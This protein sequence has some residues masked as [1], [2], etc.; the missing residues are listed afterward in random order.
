MT[1]RSITLLSLCLA[2][3]NAPT[4]RQDS[5]CD[6]P[7]GFVGWSG[8]NVRWRGLIVDASPHGLGFVSEDCHRRGAAIKDISSGAEADYRAFQRSRKTSWVRVELSAKLT[9]NGLIITKF[10]RLEA[11]SDEAALR[12]T[13]ALGF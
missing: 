3:C 5:L 4:P 6:L 13:R 11:I 10:H 2:A 9:D 12:R 8:H 7:R 1:T